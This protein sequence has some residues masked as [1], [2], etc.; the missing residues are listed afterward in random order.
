MKLKIKIIEHQSDGNISESMWIEIEKRI[1]LSAAEPVCL[2]PSINVCLIS[3]SIPL[4]F[5]F[6]LNI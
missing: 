5:F 1:T 6:F 2:N 3:N 4:F